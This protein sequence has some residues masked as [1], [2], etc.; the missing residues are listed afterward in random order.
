MIIFENEEEEL[1]MFIIGI[2]F[3]IIE[4]IF[5]MIIGLPSIIFTMIGFIAISCGLFYM[6]LDVI[7]YLKD[8]RKSLRG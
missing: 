5:I 4:L 7:L 2:I 6:L 3:C 1:T 8:K